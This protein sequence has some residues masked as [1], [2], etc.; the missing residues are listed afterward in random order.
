MS[1]YFRMRQTKTGAWP[2]R[3]D[4]TLPAA[5]LE[6]GP[7]VRELVESRRI[8]FMELLTPDKYRE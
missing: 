2:Y 4:N 6:L 1:L 8:E 5:A 7:Q 3:G